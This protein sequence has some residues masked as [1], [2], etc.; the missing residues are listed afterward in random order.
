MQKH[1]LEALDKAYPEWQK[2]VADASFQKFIGDSATRTEMFRKADTEYRSDLAIELFDWYSQTKLS[3][4]TQE[5]V[6]EEKSKIDK[7]AADELKLQEEE[8]K[9]KRKEELVAK[10]K[11]RQAKAKIDKERVAKYA[12]EKAEKD[13]LIKEK[14]EQDR[15]IEFEKK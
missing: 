3:G 5:A 4:A 7:E 8:T 10:E 11:A 14:A 1:N 12:L 13:R 9:I 6:A 15:A 2:T